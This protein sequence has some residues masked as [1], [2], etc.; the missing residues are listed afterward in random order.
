MNKI[1]VYTCITGNYDNLYEISEKSDKIDYICFTDNKNLKSSTWT[2]KYFSDIDGFGILTNSLSSVKQQ[3]LIKILSHKFLSEYD[4]TFWIDANIKIQHNIYDFITSFDLEKYPI[5]TNKHPTRN[6]VYQETLAIIKLKKDVYTN[7]RPQILRYKSERY[8]TNN[9]LAETNLILRNNKDTR[10]QLLE[11]KWAKE[12]LQGSHRDQLSF[13]YIIWQ[14]RLKY[15]HLN[16]KYRFTDEKDLFHLYKHTRSALS[17]SQDFIKSSSEIQQEKNCE[18][19]FQNFKFEKTSNEFPILNVVMTTHNRTGVACYCIDALVKNLKYSGKIQYI[20]CDDRSDPGHCEALEYQFKQNEIFD[21]IIL[22]TDENRYGLGASL[23]NGLYN[24]F[25]RSDIVLTTEDDW[26]LVK[27]LNMDLYV[28][29]ITENKEIGGIRLATTSYNGRELADFDL[30]FYKFIYNSSIK[31]LNNNYWIFNNQVMLRHKR[32][33]DKL[34]Y[35]KENCHA[36]EQERTFNKIFNEYTDFGSKYFLT[37]FPKCIN[38]ETSLFG[39]KNYFHHIGITTMPENKVKHRYLKP[40]YFNINSKE[41]EN[42]IRNKALDFLKKRIKFSIITPMHNSEK[43]IK[44]CIDSV[45]SLNFDNFEWIVVDDNSTDSSFEIVSDYA[46]KY[47]NIKVLKYTGDGKAGGARNFGLKNIADDS[48]YIMFLD[49]DDYFIN[50][51][52]LSELENKILSEN[53]DCYLISYFDAIQNKKIIFKNDNCNFK[54]I[55]P[56]PWIKCCKRN[57]IPYF[58]EKLTCCNDTLYTIQLFNN[59]KTFGFISKESIY[60]SANI[61]HTSIWSEFR[62]NKTIKDV[63]AINSIK[64]T[65]NDLIGFSTNNKEIETYKLSQI[66]FLQKVL[67]TVEKKNS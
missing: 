49:S 30:S 31:I 41:Y 17:Y 25:E 56:A 55:S 28:K 21:V 53:K 54:N 29:T 13:D 65:L 62:Q 27:E 59:I 26:L 9:G 8:P 32:V 16:V 18:K 12:I 39:Q 64:Q 63:N 48:Q 2:I 10:N 58:Q 38:K 1:A 57:L 14:N 22:K 33:Y 36:D 11:L 44:K 24:S 42:N 35:Y 34:G 45:I 46:K 5:Y 3:R 50:K 19:N 23:N 37:L 6:C 7:M 40:E 66:C 61:N 60:Y 20:I 47:S 67:A 4:I 51:D 43:F 15:S 52:L